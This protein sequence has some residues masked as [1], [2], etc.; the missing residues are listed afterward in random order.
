MGKFRKLTKAEEAGI[1]KILAALVSQGLTMDDIVAGVKRKQAAGRPPG[2]GRDAGDGDVTEPT[3]RQRRR[4][5]GAMPRAGGSGERHRLIGAVP[6]PP[7]H[8]DDHCTRRRLTMDTLKEDAVSRRADAILLTKL[9]D[10]L[11]CTLGAARQCAGHKPTAELLYSAEEAAA[12]MAVLRLDRPPALRVVHPFALAGPLHWPIALE[13]GALAG[14]DPGA[15]WLSGLNVLRIGVEAR[16]EA[17]AAA[18]R[19]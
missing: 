3:R 6:L 17:L 19:G 16:L 9:R 1:D 15:E 14:G 12:L 18:E 5:V 10:A 11:R 2:N 8:C 13:G 4:N 7:F